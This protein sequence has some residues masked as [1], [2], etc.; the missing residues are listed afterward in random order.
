MTNVFMVISETA[1]F[2]FHL[3]GNDRAVFSILQFLQAGQDFT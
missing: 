1:V 2:I 3:H